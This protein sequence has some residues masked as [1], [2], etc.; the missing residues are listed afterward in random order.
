VDY[1]AIGPVFG[2]SS[3]E[4]PDPVVGLEGVKRVRAAV[5]RAVKLVAI[6]GITYETAPAVLEAGADSVAIIGA[7]LDTS[8]PTEITRRTR[9]FL[10]RL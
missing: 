6:G 9:D 1:I 3:K 10:A 5:G 2:T 8:D 7:L 4:N